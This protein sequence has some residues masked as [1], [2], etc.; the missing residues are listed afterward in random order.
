MNKN[1]KGSII[2]YKTPLGQWMYGKVYAITNVLK[3]YLLDAYNQDTNVII[4]KPKSEVE[5]IGDIY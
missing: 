1:K 3:I 4:Y 2:K 5:F